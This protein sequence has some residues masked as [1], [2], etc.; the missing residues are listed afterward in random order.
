MSDRKYKRDM[1]F[2]Y[3]LILI[4]G[5]DA[6]VSGGAAVVSGGGAT[7]VSG[8]A[9]V[10]SGGACVVVSVPGPGVIPPV[11]ANTA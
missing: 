4:Y 11:A 6:V 1:H 3:L 10:V 8:G 7:V 5:V 9:A 2:A